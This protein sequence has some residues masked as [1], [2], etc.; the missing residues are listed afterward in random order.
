M[1]QLKNRNL[2]SSMCVPLVMYANPKIIF[3]YLEHVNTSKFASTMPKLNTNDDS[4]TR[5]L[6]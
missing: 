3:F 6:T 2:P 4:K 5:S 1:V